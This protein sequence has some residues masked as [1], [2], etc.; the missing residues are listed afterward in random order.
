MKKWLSLPDDYGFCMI[1]L[2]DVTNNGDS[3]ESKQEECWAMCL[4]YEPFTM[5]GDVW[6]KVRYKVLA[7]LVTIRGYDCFV[8]FDENHSGLWKLC[9]KTTGGHIAEG[10]TKEAAVE[11]AES[12]LDDTPNFGEQV[13]AL[14]SVMNHEEVEADEAVVK[15]GRIG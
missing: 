5:G 6:R 12:L 14:G 8:F 1:R 11:L 2:N 13:S 9:E 7:Q 4:L 10:K 3:P 15:T